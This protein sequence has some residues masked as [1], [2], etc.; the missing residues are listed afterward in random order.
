MTHSQMN[1]VTVR[2][3]GELDANS[4]MDVDDQIVQL[5]AEGNARF[6]INAKDLTYISSAGLGVFVSH[7]DEIELKKG[8]IVFSQM[9]DSVRSVFNL[10]GLDKIITI[11]NTEA[12]EILK[13]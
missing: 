11:V 13:A 6:H 3:V 10:L 1:Y 4:S 5:L 9:R 2:P 7:L 8:K 12:A